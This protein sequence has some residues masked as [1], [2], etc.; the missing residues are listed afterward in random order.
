MKIAYILYPEVIISNK[1]NGIR[2]QAETWAELLRTK[3]HEVDY[4]NN[5]GD[6]NWKEFDVIHFFGGGKWMF[7]IVK[8]M[9]AINPNLCWSP[10]CDP[11]FSTEFSAKEKIKRWTSDFLKWDY[12]YNVKKDPSLKKVLVRTQFEYDYLHK[13]YG[14]PQ[15]I[16]T[17]IPL[18]YSKYCT[19]YEKCKKEDFCLHISS[20][21]QDRKNVVRL[22]H[23][24]N[25]YNFQLV[26]AG[27]K[28]AEEQFQL[29]KNAI[30]DNTNIEVLGFISEE[31][32]ID[33][34]RRAK[35]FALPSI[36]EGV[37]I[38][39]LDAAY[40][41]C[42]IVITDIPGPKEYYNGQCIEVNPFDVDAIG[43][44]I[45]RF[46]NEEVSFQPSL[47]KYILGTYSPEIIAD[48]VESVYYQMIKS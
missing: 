9:S 48:S 42:D 19:S 39:A 47:S 8:R 11:K 36:S 6:Y 26:L 38:V 40:Y 21:Y 1:S 46:L 20:I 23:A 5:W 16:L 10:I 28:G 31:E 35:V 18:S 2:S 24:A 14:I 34:Y 44:S 17:L 3:G 7:P 15:D 12:L 45:T 4:V 43:K 27:S 30:G 29:I 13:T 32:K 22:I 37:G 33:L 25:K 41:G